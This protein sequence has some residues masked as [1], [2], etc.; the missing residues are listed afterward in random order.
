MVLKCRTI[1]FEP[2]H[3]VEVVNSKENKQE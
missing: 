2:N 1:I 3:G